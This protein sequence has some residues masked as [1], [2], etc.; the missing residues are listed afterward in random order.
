[1]A[2]HGQGDLLFLLAALLKTLLDQFGRPMR[3]LEPESV[4]AWKLST[5]TFYKA[6]N[7]PWKL[8]DIRRGV[9][10]IGLV[11]KVDAK[12]INPR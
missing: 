9:G 4:V 1:M 10:Y 7:R 11:F 12:G 5:A 8:E 2:I 3:Q 6:G